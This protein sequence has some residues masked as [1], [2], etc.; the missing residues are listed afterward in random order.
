MEGYK[1]TS[2]LRTIVLMSHALLYCMY[3]LLPHWP[4][5]LSELLFVDVFALSTF[6][7]RISWCRLFS[8]VSLAASAI[9]TLVTAHSIICD[10]CVVRSSMAF[11][12]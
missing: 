12:S 8:H 5:C 1:Q 10:S 2:E 4:S 7:T 3:L 9:G 6:N 11:C